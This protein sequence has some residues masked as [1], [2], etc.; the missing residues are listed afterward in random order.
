MAEEKTK[1]KEYAIIAMV[2]LLVLIGII[3]A[4]VNSN[5]YRT[6]YIEED[7][8]IEWLTVLSLFLGSLICIGRACK[9]RLQNG[10]FFLLG[11][12]GLGAVFLFGIGEEI[13][14]GQRI[15]DIETPSFFSKYNAQ[16][17][18]NIHNLKFGGVKLNKLIFGLILSIAMITYLSLSPILYR[19]TSWGKKLITSLAIPIP[20]LI[21]II[22]YIVL[23]LILLS[24]SSKDR[25]EMLEF[26]AGTLFVCIVLFPANLN[27]FS[28]TGK[29]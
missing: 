12:C 28:I 17:E 6:V 10:I 29:K 18:T 20:K 26:G 25:G 13:S 21:Y 23:F 24:I 7:G 1:R 27:I 19:T 8:F 22:S 4:K 2:F 15:F 11:L 9:I 3:L 16:K 14:W 5:Y